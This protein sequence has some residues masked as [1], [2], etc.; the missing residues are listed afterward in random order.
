MASRLERQQWKLKRARLP[1]G[2]APVRRTGTRNPSACPDPLRSAVIDVD[3]D[4]VGNVDVGVVP[5][6][7]ELA[8]EDIKQHEHHDDQHDD[9]KYSAP[10][11]ATAGLDYGSMLAL[12]T[13]I[14][15]HGNSPCL[16]CCTGETNEL[17]RTGFREETDEWCRR[18]LLLA[19]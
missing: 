8:A 9:G 3:V 12:R 18:G 6:E 19:C 10:A 1:H 16:T 7:A 15:G 14:I 5:A 2:T 4:L 17:W 13:V 11:A